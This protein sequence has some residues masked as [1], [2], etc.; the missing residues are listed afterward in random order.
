MRRPALALLLLFAAS[1]V[2]SDWPSWRGPRG[3]GTWDAPRLPAR[4]SAG[5]LKTVWK[6]PTGGGYAGIAIADGRVYV[7]DLEAT[8]TPRKDDRSDAA[9]RLR[10]FDLRTGEVRW[11]KSYPVRYGTLGGYANGPRAQPT[12]HAGRA[13]TLGATGVL[14][15]WDVAGEVAWE[16][17]LVKE[18]GAAVPEWGFAGSPLV[19][20]DQ[21]VVT[22]GGKD[23]V[24]VVAFDP[25][26]GKEL[27]RSLSDPAGYCAPV[28][29]RA[30]TGEQFVVF[31]PEHVHG[32]DA[33]TGRPLWRVP[34]KVT[35]GVA[36]AP[37]VYAEGLVLVSGYWEGAKA[38]RLG[39]KATDAEVVWTDTKNL[40][41]LMA[42]PLVRG[43]FGYLI[44]KD[45]GL[46]GFDLRTGKKLWDDDNQLTPRGRN[47]HASVVWLDDGDRALAL[48]ASGELVLCRLTPEWYVEESRA[49]VLTGRVWGHPA[50]S[51]RRMVAK[52]DGGE[53]WRTAGPLEVVCV[54]LVP[55]GR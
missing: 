19:H 22:V 31:T 12:L 34:Y 39:P 43:R 29:I 45:H 17:D 8:A 27:W 50:F 53:A 25:A 2:G 3:D 10:C 55:E 33:R 4:W 41:A 9:E 26:S 21:L 6:H 30:P 48:N 35:Y 14:R 37:P 7:F 52:T 5:G 46:T 23:G 13:Y 49:K 54:E 1:A 15:C 20:A 18:F 44:D 32:L 24:G 11:S 42:Q 28:L 16:R 47:P 51:G 40:R 36:I 38:I